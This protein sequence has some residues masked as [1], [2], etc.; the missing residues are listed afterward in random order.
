MSIS[1]TSHT[2]SISSTLSSSTSSTSSTSSSARVKV[3]YRPT[4]PQ[5]ILP[6]PVW[7][8][9]TIQ[10]V[11]ESTLP[12]QPTP[13]HPSPSS[14]TRCDWTSPSSA[15]VRVLYYEGS[16][17]R[18]VTA[19]LPVLRPWFWNLMFPEKKK[20]G[21]PQGACR[22]ARGTR[23]LEMPHVWVQMIELCVLDDECTGTPHL[24]SHGCTTL[25]GIDKPLCPAS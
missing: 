4:P 9:V 18:R 19:K 10:C 24:G 15:R 25:S 17:A 5:P 23:L 3:C 6:Y 2:W 22:A 11:C 13:P 14:L 1:S 7:L 12:S 16:T 8:D 20:H 21:F